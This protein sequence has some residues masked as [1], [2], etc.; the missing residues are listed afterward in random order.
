[1]SRQMCP[2]CGEP[3]ERAVF[4]GSHLLASCG[5]ATLPPL[6]DDTDETGATSKQQ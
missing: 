6:I 2:S 1:M 4:D 3:L 5:C